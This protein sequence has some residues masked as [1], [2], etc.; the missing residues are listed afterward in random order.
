MISKPLKILIKVLPF[1]ILII[2]SLM[3]VYYTWGKLAI[4][5]DTILPF[6]SEAVTKFLWQWYGSEN[7]QYLSQNLVPLFLIYKTAEFLS[8]NIFITASILIFSL[9]FIAGLA[10]YK[11]CKLIY[12][13][14]NTIYL[15]IPI[16][17]YLFSPALFNCW[18]YC[19]IYSFA[20]W[21]IYFI[22]KILITRRIT[23]IDII[24][25]NIVI[26]F[27]S[28]DLPNPKYLFFL[29]LFAFVAMILALLLKIITFK[30]ILRNWFK[31]VLFFLLSSYLFFPLVFFATNYSPENYS[32]HIKQ[33]YSDTGRF[34][35][36]GFSTID[37]MIQLHNN[38]ESINAD[39]RTLYNNSKKTV[40]AG[41]VFYICILVSFLI[42]RKNQKSKIE[43]LFLS[44][45]CLYLLFA[46]G[47]NLPLGFMYKDMVSKIS[48]L[49]FLR[50]TA[51]A[52]FFLSIFYSLL[53]FGFIEKSKGKNKI[54]LSIIIL[55]ALYFS[56]YPIINGSYYEN[57]DVVGNYSIDKNSHG[58]KLPKEYFDAKKQIDQIKLDGKLLN[59]TNDLAYAN[60]KWGYFGPSPYNLLFNYY[61]IGFNSIFSKPENH[62]VA[63]TLNDKSLI[64]IGEK[65]VMK[66]DKTSVLLDNDILKLSAVSS[67]DYLPHFWVPTKSYKEDQFLGDLTETSA[68]KKFGEAVYLTSQNKLN[69]QVLNG[70][71]ETTAVKPNIE[72][73]KINPTK[74]RVIVH[75]A[76][77]VF[78]LIFNETFSNKWKIYLENYDIESAE[79]LQDSL[80]HYSKLEGNENFQATKDELSSY[81]GLGMI[82]ELKPEKK[83]KSNKKNT[84][85]EFIS[86][87]MSGT[88]QNDNI[89]N[90]SFFETWTQEPLFDNDRLIANGYA[91]SW[92]IDVNK[93]CMQS[94]HCKQNPDGS[95]DFEMVVEFVPQRIFWMGLVIS[96]AAVIVSLFFIVF[97]MLN[98]KKE[99][100]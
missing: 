52:V 73:K 48:V 88:I 2:V 71:P 53:L 64:I 70:L 24:L 31:L 12:N 3:P 54:I 14:T 67:D 32:V 68:D 60:T 51:G 45:I 57:L 98:K 20:P 77:S 85:L 21:F 13:P 79:S 44:M 99:N 63:Y 4:G 38:G 8:I 27:A 55:L 58:V 65:P 30:S 28:I 59:L 96:L 11:L 75:Q 62:S 94:N 18:R 10:I 36:Q 43:L 69:K 50:T 82:S 5:G 39:R 1:L 42:R 46:V 91:N 93:I 37:R 95:Y 35:D 6:N 74:Y 17:F 87:N 40:L 72:Y 92:L 19:F 97:K 84:S 56:S 100:I 90:G 86:K 89:S 7:G 15:I 25:A 61:N 23:F 66:I 47:P 78:P 76:G 49:A 26:F 33:N 9:N 29:Y 22:V 80:N 34:M 16:L 41:S 81:L 83:N